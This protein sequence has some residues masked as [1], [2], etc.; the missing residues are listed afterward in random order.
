MPARL[1]TQNAKTI[2]DIVV[3]DAFNEARQ[4]FLG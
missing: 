4:H 3:G 2:L 1:G